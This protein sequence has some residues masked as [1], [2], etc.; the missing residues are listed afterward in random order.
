MGKIRAMP[1]SARSQR[2]VGHEASEVNHEETRRDDGTQPISR[3]VKVLLLAFFTVLSSA[4]PSSD[5]CPILLNLLATPR[6][7]Q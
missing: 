5:P 6:V 4:S 3:D 2:W 7:L 1:T